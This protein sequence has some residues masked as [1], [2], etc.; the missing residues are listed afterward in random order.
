MSGCSASAPSPPRGMA[1]PA[2]ARNV[3]G[4]SAA[5]GQ[6]EVSQILLGGT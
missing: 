2:I 1:V 5:Q 3:A 6:R 4:W